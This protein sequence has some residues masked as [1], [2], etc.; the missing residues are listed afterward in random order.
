MWRTLQRRL[1]ARWSDAV[2]ITACVGGLAPD[3]DQPMP[4]AM[5][6]YLQ[7][8]WRRIAETVPGVRFN[9]DFWRRCEPRRSTYPACRAVLAARR[10][11]R[12]SEDAMVLA[13]QQAYYLHARNPSDAA[14]LTDC[15]AA[16]G[17]AP[18]AFDAAF[19]DPARHA[20]L[21]QELRFVRSLGVTGFPSL[22]LRTPTGRAPIAP[23][24]TDVDA[25]LSAIEAALVRTP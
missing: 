21:A 25:M 17:L 15:A 4:P 9:A 3:S 2:A 7:Q 19:H 20:E 22:V 1:A 14:V 5:R 11:A 13:I 8:V 18:A 6:E 24:Y 16:V 23:H 10:L 12:S